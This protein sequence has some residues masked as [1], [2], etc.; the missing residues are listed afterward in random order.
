MKKYLLVITLLLA[1]AS[2]GMIGNPTIVIDE[3]CTYKK[4]AKL[5]LT[6]IVKNTKQQFLRRDSSFFSLSFRAA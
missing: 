6:P 2:Y 1:N 4:F 5:I 3:N